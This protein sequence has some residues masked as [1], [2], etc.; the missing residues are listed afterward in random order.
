MTNTPESRQRLLVAGP[1]PEDRELTV[2]AL[3]ALGYD[4]V[5]QAP[6]GLAAIAA[7]ARHR[8]D[9]VVVDLTLPEALDGAGAAR[10]IDEIYGIPAVVVAGEGFGRT[11]GSL[12][13]VVLRKPF[14]LHDLEAAVETALHRPAPERDRGREWPPTADRDRAFAQLYPSREVQYVSRDLDGAHDLDPDPSGEGGLNDPTPWRIPP[15]S[16]AP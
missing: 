15:P 14:D 1:D 11:P 13:Y 5:D 12:A 3:S 8:P 7:A 2:R 10:A 4:I 16:D 9:L 6:S